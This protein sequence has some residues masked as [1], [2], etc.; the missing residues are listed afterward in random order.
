MRYY[1]FFCTFLADDI[2]DCMTA[3]PPK[4]L[5]LW[6]LLAGKTLAQ[7]A[8]EVRLPAYI[9]SA[10]ERGEVT[11][12][13]RWAKRFAAA[14]GEAV[15]ADLLMPVEPIEALGQAAGGVPLGVKPSDAS[16]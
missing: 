13:D 15:A 1:A 5:R 14:Y 16:E 4:K 7:V 8:R 12:P 6:R 10:I 2:R 3:Q 9:V 11:P